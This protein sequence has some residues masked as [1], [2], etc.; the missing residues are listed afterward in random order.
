MNERTANNIKSLRGLILVFDLDDTITPY[1]PI[2]D[3]S[4][5]VLN[6][7]MITIL[8]RALI[9]KGSN[10]ENV[11]GIFLYTNNSDKE[12]IDFIHGLLSKELGVSAD[13]FDDILWASEGILNSRKKNIADIEDLCKRNNISTDD[14][15]NR[16][17][18]F[19]DQ[20]HNNLLETL[21]KGHYILIKSRVPSINYNMQGYVPAFNSATNLTS[22]RSAL[23]MTGGTRRFI[24]HKTRRNKK[25]Y[26]RKH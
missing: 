3:A 24:R 25:R 21:S 20:I 14:L 7:D 22:V 4:N 10:P 23:R 6:P 18:F 12:Y 5:H 17:Y 15:P 13:V 26:S 19:D 11:S 2:N 9:I 8:K 1:F 16:V